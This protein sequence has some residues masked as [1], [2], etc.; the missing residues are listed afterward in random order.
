MNKSKKKKDCREISVEVTDVRVP[1]KPPPIVVN[2]FFNPVLMAHHLLSKGVVQW[3]EDKQWLLF[4]DMAG[5]SGD[6][7]DYKKFSEDFIHYNRILSHSLWAGQV[8]QCLEEAIKIATQW[9]ETFNNLPSLTI[10]PQDIPPPIIKFHL[11]EQY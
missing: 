2:V 9:V 11:G 10:K 1:Y 6:I 5:D 8:T 3:N 7:F 4:V